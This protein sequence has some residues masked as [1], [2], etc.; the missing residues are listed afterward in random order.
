MAYYSSQ[1]KSSLTIKSNY[2][3]TSTRLGTQNRSI[4]Q[5]PPGPWAR[6]HGTSCFVTEAWGRRSR[7]KH[8]LPSHLKGVVAVGVLQT[9][10]ALEWD[11]HLLGAD[12]E[13]SEMEKRLPMTRWKR[14]STF[15][16]LCSQ[17]SS[18]S[19]TSYITINTLRLS[20]K[21]RAFYNMTDKNCLHASEPLVAWAGHPEFESYPPGRIL[22]T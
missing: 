16:H 7:L 5:G 9:D 6:P 10:M 20:E 4:Q 22:L 2:Y 8:P 12:R 14:T 1:Y 3:G 15:G 17:C 18:D 11:Q 19:Y 13:D 21:M